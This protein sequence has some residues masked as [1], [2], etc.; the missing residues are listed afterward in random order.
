MAAQD[1]FLSNTDVGATLDELDLLV[2]KHGL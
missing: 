1:D 2:K